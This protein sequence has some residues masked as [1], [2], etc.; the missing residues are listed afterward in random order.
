[1]QFRGHDSQGKV[2]DF[3][4]CRPY[5]IFVWGGIDSEL[6]GRKNRVAQKSEF[7]F[8]RYSWLLLA[9]L[10]LAFF[11][12]FYH[13][14]DRPLYQDEA[15]Y[16]VP[17]AMKSVAYILSTNFGSILYSLILHFLL[18]LGKTEFMARLPAAIFGFMSVWM[19][20][21]IGRGLFGKKVAI[22]A[23]FLSATS[24]QFIYFSKQARGYSGLLLFSLLSL[25]FFL[26]ALKKN[27][28]L[29][30]VLY[31]ITMAI[32]VQ[33]HFFALVILPVH[34]FVFVFRLLEH[35]K[36]KLRAVKSIEAKKAAL[37]FGLSV[38]LVLLLVFSF[39]YP[40]RNWTEKEN[41]FTMFPHSVKSLLTGH[42]SL[43]PISFITDNLKR[44]LDYYSSH[45]L[46]YTKLVLIF[47]GIFVAA[48][49]KPREMILFISYIL[50]PLLLFIFSNPPP[51]YLPADNKFIFIMPFLILLL[52]I[53]VTG[54]ASVLA[55]GIT[56]VV[57]NKSR[58]GLESTAFILLTLLLVF[59]ECSYFAG[60]YFA[61]WDIQSLKRGSQLSSYMK[62]HA[63]GREMLF[64]DSPEA[65]WETLNVSS[66]VYPDRKKKILL[67]EELGV[68]IPKSTA[69][70]PGGLWVLLSHSYPDVEVVSKWSI[71]SGAM[72]IKFLDRACLIHFSSTGMPLWEKLA[73]STKLILD[74]PIGHD[75]K[76][77]YRLFL[78]KVYL[79][80]GKNRDAL[81]ELETSRKMKAGIPAKNR[82]GGVQ[83][84]L[85]D[86]IF[87]LLLE[88]AG[89]A[90]LDKKE[91]E[92]FSL[93]KSAEDISLDEDNDL[94]FRSVGEDL[95]QMKTQALGRIYFSQAEAFSRKGMKDEAR[96][97][98]EQALPFCQNQNEEEFVIV[99]IREILGLS[100]GYLIWRQDNFW[101]CRWWSDHLT[102]FSGEITNIPSSLKVTNSWL[103]KSDK[104]K[105]S[106]EKL[107]FTG[108]SEKGRL[109][110]FSFRT[111]TISRLTWLLKI[112]NDENVLDKIVIVGNMSHPNRMP[113]YLD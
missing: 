67:V 11:L 99:K 36:L 60:D 58:N 19:I 43:D 39:Y 23:A 66:A 69:L 44:Q 61:V 89:Q 68:G 9:I 38:A 94:F 62:E 86:S 32:A 20:Y 111:Q 17:T 53:G 34:M 45:V 14:G 79:L 29:D 18:P 25:H 22:L 92:A 2:L 74:L 65:L 105:K 76:I 110:G 47:F 84:A 10:V 91:Q 59:G 31:A 104:V 28:R 21:S 49:N 80:A 56:K 8:N 57:R 98:Y 48:K 112:K 37:A 107:A 113:F 90:M 73:L 6:N 50:L 24:T 15:V 33:M 75:N 12:R 97:K 5:S 4:L 103:T 41:L 96:I 106:K 70:A 63:V 78:A 40:S 64:A 95:Q 83:G 87:N 77:T 72:D 26:S 46:F 100:C 7:Q 35:R 93:W 102:S 109:K 16:T 51:V 27:K 101:R 42:L 54:V 85:Y 52:A 3:D 1:V 81:Q 55:G 108:I 88:N 82:W 30:W 71:S 13:L